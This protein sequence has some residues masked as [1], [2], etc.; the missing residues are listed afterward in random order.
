MESK[1]VGAVVKKDHGESRGPRASMQKNV[2][3]AVG[4]QM[5]SSQGGETLPPAVNS[6]CSVMDSTTGLQPVIGGF[7]SPQEC[8]RRAG[9][10]MEAHETL[11]LVEE[12]SIP[13]LSAKTEGWQSGLLHQLAKLE[14]LIRSVGSNPT[15]SSKR[16]YSSART[17]RLL[18]T[19]DA[20]GSNPATAAIE[21]CDVDGHVGCGVSRRESGSAPT[22][23]ERAG[24]ILPDSGEI[25]PRSDR[26]GDTLQGLSVSRNLMPTVGNAVSEIPAKSTSRY[27]VLPALK[28]YRGL[29]VRRRTVNPTIAGSIPAGTAKSAYSSV[30]EHQTFNLVTQVRFLVGAP[31]RSRKTGGWPRGLWRY[32]YKVEIEGSTPS[33]PTIVVV[34]VATLESARGLIGQGTGLLN[35]YVQVRILASVRTLSSMVEHRVHNPRTMVRF[36]Q[37]PPAPVVERIRR[38]ATNQEN[39]GLNPPGRTSGGRP[40][41]GC[42]TVTQIIVGSTP[43]LHPSMRVS[44][45]GRASGFQPEDQSSIL[46][47]RPRMV[48]YPNRLRGWIA[49]PDLTGSSPVPISKYAW[50]AEW[51]KAR[52]C[53]PRSQKDT[54][55]R[56][57]HHAPKRRSG[58]VCAIAPVLKTGGRKVRGLE[59]HLLFHN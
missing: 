54:V 36:H 44:S 13:P 12:G 20:A 6:S 39:G 35:R 42:L 15:L 57:H 26:V 30:V 10:V 40:M 22:R 21:G 16:W 38:L 25:R 58:R 45:S 46:C 24:R 55:V 59:S 48:G 19:Q 31:M 56:I 47:T 43:T 53:S 52:G 18:V 41:V 1:H 51:L 33:S 2:R 4:V 50:L 23:P 8:Q 27:R 34:I 28:L 32:S 7:D 5:G 49:N 29:T 11:T 14:A 17:E 9:S 3:G 37:G